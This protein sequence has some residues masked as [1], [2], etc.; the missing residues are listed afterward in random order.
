MIDARPIDR[1]LGTQAIEQ[2]LGL[3]VV[4]PLAPA[5]D[6]QSTVQ[7]DDLEVVQELAL[8]SQQRGVDRP[9][10]ADAGDIV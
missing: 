6:Q 3:Q 5:I 2:Q 8:G 4:D 10:R 1:H 9:R 7:F